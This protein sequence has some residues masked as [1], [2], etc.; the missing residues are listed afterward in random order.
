M[1]TYREAA[2]EG[3]QPHPLCT[4]DNDE[5]QHNDQGQPI[6]KNQPNPLQMGDGLVKPHKIKKTGEALQGLLLKIWATKGQLGMKNIQDTHK[7][8][9]LI[10]A[11]D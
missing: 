2:I 9:H 1:E 7:F 6:T 5:D 11:Q 8:T 10:Q 4:R 3:L